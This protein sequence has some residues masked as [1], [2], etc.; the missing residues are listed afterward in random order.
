MD[1]KDKTKWT[2]NNSYH[3]NNS[4]FYV[5]LK[6]SYRMS[7]VYKMKLKCFCFF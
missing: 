2:L 1:R 7:E 4:N 3:K 6:N 5:N